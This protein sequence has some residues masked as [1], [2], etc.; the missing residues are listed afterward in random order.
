M[1]E[2]EVTKFANTR[3]QELGISGWNVEFNT[4]IHS[5]GFCNYSKRILVFSRRYIKQASSFDV[6]DTVLHEIAHIL[7]PGSHHNNVWKIKAREI[8]CS[9]ERCH[10][11]NLRM[12]QSSATT[13]KGNSTMRINVDK[14]A[15][16]N[17][18]ETELASLRTFGVDVDSILQEASDEKVRSEVSGLVESIGAGANVFTGN[19]V[20]EFYS[21]FETELENQSIRQ[22][23]IF[24]GVFEY[25]VDKSIF[26]V[27]INR[28]SHRALKR[29]AGSGTRA[30]TGYSKDNMFTVAKHINEELPDTYSVAQMMLC[31]VRSRDG[32]SV[33]GIRA[34]AEH[35]AKIVELF[36]ST[37][38]SELSE[39]AIEKKS[40]PETTESE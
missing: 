25:N 5:A 19:V 30:T 39:L 40:K 21:T 27:T 16:L 29:S 35:S 32:D 26:D 2:L 37:F 23:L 17:A 6:R 8:G 38:A 36:E 1:T 4:S 22:G 11:Y 12:N 18:S 3:M 14:D 7:T 28:I 34:G 24:K 20:S 9:A 31:L 13:D 10:D 15:I 33:K